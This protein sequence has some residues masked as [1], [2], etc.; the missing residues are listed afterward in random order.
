MTPP[1]ANPA[2][3][4]YA[5]LAGRW[6]GSLELAITDW[7]ALR[8]TAMPWTAKLAWMSMG[9]VTQLIGPARLETTLSRAHDSGDW[10][11]TT[12][13]SQ[14]GLCLLKTHER[15]CPHGD[16]IGLAMHGQ[17]AVWPRL[18]TPLSYTAQGEIDERAAEA[19]YRIP[20]LSAEVLQRTAIT[21]TG[22]LLTQETPWLRG[23]V[24]LQRR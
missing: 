3:R 20:L 12:R 2:E 24:L 4:Y 9:A 8:A 5:S 6:D 19:T 7:S 11:H 16:G 17:Q 21:E 10:L 14:I 1:S 15:I 23:Q 22:L 18:Q 13:V